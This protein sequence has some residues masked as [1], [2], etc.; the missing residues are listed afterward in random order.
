MHA[1]GVAS[2]FQIQRA[3]GS[4]LTK[5][6][7]TWPTCRRRTIP[8]ST[9]SSPPR[10]ARRW[11]PTYTIATNLTVDGVLYPTDPAPR[12]SVFERDPKRGW[13]MIAHGNFGGPAS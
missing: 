9:T 2:E 3:D 10:R 6:P 11:S 4:R 7:S 13:Q 12:L 8:V 5:R 1:S